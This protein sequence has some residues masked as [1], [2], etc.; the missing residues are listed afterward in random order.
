MIL[1][2]GGRQLEA[3]ASYTDMCDY[4][5][6]SLV[7]GDTLTFLCR[8]QGNS[9]N[10][11]KVLTHLL[12]IHLDPAMTGHPPW[13]TALSLDP[14]ENSPHHTAAAPLV[15]L[16]RRGVAVPK[17]EVSPPAEERTVD[18]GPGLDICIED[19][20]YKIVGYEETTYPESVWE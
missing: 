10:C 19:K 12:T 15:G 11:S 4:Q 5:N 16:S 6:F 3:G 1:L 2:P 14:S 9:R 7:Q 17:K 8:L 20:D 18:S 13:P